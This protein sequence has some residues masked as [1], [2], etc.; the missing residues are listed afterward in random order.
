MAIFGENKVFVFC[1]LLVWLHSGLRRSLLWVSVWGDPSVSNRN[2]LAPTWCTSVLD[3]HPTLIRNLWHAGAI[4]YE[5]VESSDVVLV[6]TPTKAG[7]M[8]M[9]PGHEVSYEF[10][11]FMEIAFRFWINPRSGSNILLFLFCRVLEEIID[12]DLGKLWLRGWSIGSTM[13]DHK[14]HFWTSLDF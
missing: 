9:V 13:K 14:V 10:S 1:F 4:N 6:D 5:L 12:L 2:V 7:N 3:Q 8:R 11:I